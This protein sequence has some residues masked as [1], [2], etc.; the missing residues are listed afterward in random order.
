[1]VKKTN[2]NIPYSL[3][4]FPKVLPQV[5]FFTKEPIENA[6]RDKSICRLGWDSD[7]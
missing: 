7:F 6:K 3:S 1:M 5:K 4:D 2:P